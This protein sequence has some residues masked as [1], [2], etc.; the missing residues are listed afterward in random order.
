MRND[1]MVLRLATIGRNGQTAQAIAAVCAGNPAIDLRQA[2]RNEADLRD[3]ASLARFI[4]AAKPDALINA[5]SYNFV[6]RAESESDEAARINT[7]G[8]RELAGLCAARS[9]PFI[10]MSTDLVFD[11][12]KSGAYIESDTPNPLSVYGRTKLAGEQA[13]AHANPHA[14]TA[15]VCWVY[16]EYADNFVSKMIDFART[17]P[18]LKVVSDQIGAPTFA[19]DIARALI[20]IAQRMHRGE[21]AL[22]R[23]LHL[24]A[25]WT[26][27]R[28]AMAAH[29][30]AESQR[31]GGPFAPVNPVLTSAFSAPAKRPLNAHMSSE[32]AT[33]LLDLKW[34]PWNE[35]L[36]RSVAGVLARQSG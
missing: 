10:H 19:P 12:E 36:A 28:A 27:S 16:S 20:E 33:S 14:I 31:L 8:P 22:P 5:G 15:R 21:S 11:G 24:S 2:D 25:P 9:I 23:I 3:P 6:D 7:A 26:T 35:G 18:R 1:R 32:L 29:V 17:Q 4:D 30:M 34:T 13:V